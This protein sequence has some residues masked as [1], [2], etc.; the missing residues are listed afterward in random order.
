MV[1]IGLAFATVVSAA[2]SI[3]GTTKV[4]ENIYVE[5]VD[6]GVTF[7]Q[8]KG[9]TYGSAT[10]NIINVIEV[11]PTNTNVKLQVFNATEKL[12]TK[13]TMANMA[14]KYNEANDGTV[15]AAINGDPWFLYHNDYDEDGNQNTGVKAKMTWL[16]R[17]MMIIDGELWCTSQLQEENNLDYSSAHGAVMGGNQPVFAVLEDGTYMIGKPSVKI[18][19]NNTTTGVS[20]SAD[21]VNRLSCS[22]KTIVYNKR[23]GNESLAYTD[24]YEIYLEVSGGSSAF[25]LG[26]TLT[27]TVTAVYASG[28]DGERPAI[29]DNTVVI[30]CRGE[31][32]TSWNGFAKE[33]DVIEI[34][35]ACERDS[36]IGKQTPKWASVTQAIGGFFTQLEKGVA[37]GQQTN[38]SQYPCPMIGVTEDGKAMLISVSSQSEGKYHGVQMRQIPQLC[39]DLGLYTVIMFDGGGSNQMITIE[40]GA[41]IRRSSSSDGANTT[42]VVVNGIGVVYTGA[43]LTVTNK[44]SGTRLEI[45]GIANDNVTPPTPTEPDTP[46][47]PVE[48]DDDADIVG[49]PISSFKYAANID[50]VNGKGK[51]ENNTPYGVGTFR[52]ADG[53]SG[54]GVISSGISTD[55]NSKLT[56]T[57]WALVN[58]GQNKYYWSVDNYNWYKCTGGRYDVD[59]S[60]IGDIRAAAIALAGL[61]AISETNSKYTEIGA[62]LKDYVGQTVTVYFGVEPLA[63]SHTGKVLPLVTIQNVEVKGH[64][65]TPGADATCTSAQVCTGCGKEITPAL[66]HDEVSHEAKAPTCTETGW[67][68]YVTC[69]RCDY[70]TYVEIPA[71]GHDIANHEAKPATCTESG[72]NAYETCSR[73]DYTT[74]AEIDALGH[75]IVNHEAKPATC[76][77]SG[78]NAYETCTRCDYTTYT[79]IDALG[80]DIVN[81]EAK[82]PTCTEIGWEAYVTCTRCDYT[83]YAEIAATGHTYDDEQ[84]AECNICGEKRDVDGPTGGPTEA[85]TDN[86]A[87]KPAETPTQAPTQA[88]A[89]E[90]KSGCGSALGASALAIIAS[91]SLAGYTVLKKKKD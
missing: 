60:N 7:T 2:P 24:A 51:D 12:A 37:T 16:C 13:S 1:M 84:D 78:H 61:N 57:G 32:A 91:V 28:T 44:E 4:S 34:T 55:D 14:N 46:T 52:N 43:D 15:I 77:E 23:I 18:T 33:G 8:Y 26:Q 66:G 21:G 39:K 50:F 58:G 3:S 79:E 40:D 22:G 20:S 83:T 59:M 81:H 76:T 82:A 71:L 42:R 45:D 89:G 69:T 56:I 88:P 62:D 6:T 64:V 75:D 9:K 5:G 65:C 25:K 11:D 48:P 80:H 19:V 73:C 85:P 41:Y 86:P 74:Y 38:T 10:D 47:E 17:S 29:G 90:A 68:S 54:V 35:P 30:S 36:F 63:S 87:D 27:A 31:K 67:E 70:T 53:L 72:H 49:D